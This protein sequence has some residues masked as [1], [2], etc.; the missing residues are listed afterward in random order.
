VDNA[1]AIAEIKAKLPIA[2]LIQQRTALQK[3]G[4]NYKGLCPF[5]GEKTPSFYVFP[6]SQSYHC[7]G[8]KESGDIFNFVMKTQGLDFGD[9]LKELA[10]RAGVQL[11]AR[12]GSSEEDRRKER[13]RQLNQAAADYFYE[14]LLRSPSAEQARAYALQR[15]VNQSG[16]MMFH[17]GYA[18]DSWDA[19]LTHL[20][21]LQYS[22][23]E[24]LAAGLVIERE[25]GGMYDRFRGRLI[26]PIRDA[27][28]RIVGFGGRALDKNTQ[29]KYMNTPQTAL[30][31]K[32]SILF[33]LDLARDSI[34]KTN[35]AVIVEGYMDAL[36]A[37]QSG[38]SNVVA[39]MGTAVGEKQI[40]L[41]KKLTA[42][43]TLALDADAAGDMAA[44][45]EA[46]LLRQ[47]MDHIAIPVYNARG[48]LGYEYKLQA[49]IKIAMLPEGEDP[50]DV[51]RR[52][53][54]EWRQII[55]KALPVVEHYLS[56]LAKKHDLATPRGKRE[57]VE[58]MASLIASVGDAVERAAYHSRLAK[59]VGVDP[60]SVKQTVENF[61]KGNKARVSGREVVTLDSRDYRPA[62]PRPAP[63]PHLRLD[64]EEAM[65]SLLLRYPELRDNPDMPD[66]TELGGT[67]A[68]LLY[69][70]LLNYSAAE[71][72]KDSGVDKATNRLPE[73]PKTGKDIDDAGIIDDDDPSLP[74]PA[75]RQT[76]DP[77]LRGFLLRLVR[78]ITDEPVLLGRDLI[79]ELATRVQRLRQRRDRL[80]LKR[81][82]AML[83]DLQES[84]DRDEV[85][86]LQML[87]EVN[88]R[89]EAMRA[90]A[91]VRSPIFR[92][93]RD[94]IGPHG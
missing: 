92:D 90:Y 69:S 20:R 13:L 59:V 53:P 46:E 43:I 2:D 76:L 86:Y 67:E 7:F 5:H 18:L 49:T 14:T 40:A 88:I 71:L 37:H 55:A 24:M 62:A 26:F 45:R 15:G 89:L 79:N 16:L 66:I 72:E 9:A 31:D 68:R 41:L 60:E 70:T 33:A 54:D 75:L 39:G 64:V 84:G 17:L 32:S 38:I 80:W 83:R 51:I 82:E 3:S 23:E 91:P 48:L 34:R 47:S 28:G 29:P 27:Q 81:S 85:A 19:L 30:F 56:L 22:D 58:Q 35:Q 94:P 44:L 78:R 74:Y 36:V 73:M 57:A 50:D 12:Q 21:G 25:G 93:S 4:R 61:V 63:T 8:C 42:N 11:E 65:L 6:E 52:N 1:S 87:T 10:G 77:A